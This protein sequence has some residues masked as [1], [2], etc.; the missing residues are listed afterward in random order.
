MCNY[1]TAMLLPE[2]QGRC[3]SNALEVGV[4][5]IGFDVVEAQLSAGLRL[6]HLIDQWEEKKL[7]KKDRKYDDLMVADEAF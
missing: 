5:P 7:D 3:C 6:E 2:D 1:E 4:E